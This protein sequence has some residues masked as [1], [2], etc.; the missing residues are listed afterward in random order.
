MK[1]AGDISLAAVISQTIVPT[2]AWTI[3]R[4]RN[5]AVF[6]KAR[7]EEEEPVRRRRVCV[8]GGSFV[9]NLHIKM[10][11][12]VEACTCPKCMRNAQDVRKMTNEFII[13]R[14][15]DMR[16][17]ITSPT[18]QFVVD[19]IARECSCN[20][21][22]LTGMPCSHAIALIQEIRG[23]DI[24]EFIDPCYYTEAYRSTYE[25][26]VNPLMDRHL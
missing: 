19:L 11:T 1:K 10:C 23:L 4:T 7:C 22:T 8:K 16:A 26:R 5:A 24:V 13:R 17:E 12:E 14:S 25:L 15:D 21:W 3:W 6:T 9:Q 2:Q 20:R 18:H